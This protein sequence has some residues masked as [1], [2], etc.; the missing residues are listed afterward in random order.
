MFKK[1]RKSLD[2]GHKTYKKANILADKVMALDENHDK[3]F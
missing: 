1:L 2:A 3:T